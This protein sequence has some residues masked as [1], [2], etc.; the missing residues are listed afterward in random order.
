MDDQMGAS[1]GTALKGSPC[2]R[3]RCLALTSA[4]HFINDGTVFLIPLIAAIVALK[5][6]ITPLDVTVMLAAFYATSSVL[7]TYVGVIADRTGRQGALIGAGLALLSIGLLGFYL[8]VSRLSGTSLLAGIIG[9]ALLTGFGSA[10]YHPL[11]ATLLGSVFGSEAQGRALGING[12]VGSVGR[13]LYPS[14][15]FA[16]SL[17]LV[18]SGSFAFF[19]VVGLAASAALWAG[20]R[21][22]GPSKANGPPGQG[23]KPR[24]AGVATRS[25]TTL[26]VVA[27]VR[28]FAT[29]GVVAWIPI[30]ISVQKGLGVTSDLGL[31][32]TLMYGAAIIGQPLFGLLADRFDKRLILGLSTLGV[33]LSIFGYVVTTGGA[34]GTMLFLFGFFTFSAFPLFLSLVSDYVP[35]GSSTSGNAVVWGLGVTGGGVI[36]PLVV[37]ALLLPDYSNLGTVFVFMAGAAVIA[38]IGSVILPRVA[39]KRRTPLFG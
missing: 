14:I 3:L 37:G 26:T 35:R 18:D 5:P 12:A 10:F 38:A 9:S 33:S 19:A 7:S 13:A 17:F 23:P 15:Y 32:L 20:F 16:V 6:G 31:S 25:I 1:G 24:F 2:G 34:E 21:S 4:A 11:G 29:Q 27:F 8:A 36:G 39:R 30:F 22:S 28:S